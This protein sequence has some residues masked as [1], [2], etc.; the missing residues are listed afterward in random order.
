MA[1][2]IS[3]AQAALLSSSSLPSFGQQRDDV[4]V[5]LDRADSAIIR[6]AARF[7]TDAQENLINADRNSSGAL[8]ESI[9]PKVIEWGNGVNIVQVMVAPYYKFVDS[10]VQGLKGGTSLK[11][12]KFRYAGVSKSMA[13]N[14]EE[15][16]KRESIAFRNTKKA[17]TPREQKRATIT[18]ASR[19]AAIQI[20]R[21]IKRK[22]LQPTRFWSDALIELEKDIATGVASALRIDVIENF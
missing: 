13:D 16:V 14:L 7:V 22:G 5:A 2:S 8:S 11:G 12:Y 19:A 21:S 20:G 15:W 10:G 17:V 6:A 3:Q 1:I 18:S 9:Q 4:G